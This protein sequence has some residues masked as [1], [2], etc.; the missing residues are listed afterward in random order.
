MSE[1]SEHLTKEDFMQSGFEIIVAQCDEKDCARYS[2]RFAARA[3]E[4]EEVGNTTAQ[5]VFRLLSSITSLHLKLDTSEDP[6]GPMVVFHDRR[7]AIVDDFD[8]NQLTL[9]SDV[10]TDIND[11]ELRARIADVLWLRKRDYRM[12]ELAISSYLESAK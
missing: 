10:V 3:R 12:A 4:A 11:P 9:L 5:G 1:V 6:F 7:T 8:E 2:S